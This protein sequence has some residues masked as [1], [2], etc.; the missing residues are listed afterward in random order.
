MLGQLGLLEPVTKQDLAG[1]PASSEIQKLHV[2]FDG[3]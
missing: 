1:L 3:Y 2:M